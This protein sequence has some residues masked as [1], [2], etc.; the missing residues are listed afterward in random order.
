MLKPYEAVP[1]HGHVGDAGAKLSRSKDG[2]VPDRSSFS[3]GIRPGHAVF[4][5]TGLGTGSLSGPRG[6]ETA[7]AE[8]AVSQSAAGGAIKAIGCRPQGRELGTQSRAEPCR[9]GQS[10]GAESAAGGAIEAQEEERKQESGRTFQTA[11]A[12]R[13][14]ASRRRQ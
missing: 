7:T 10:E 8:L 1:I 14:T 5:R 2:N 13:A 12:G 4:K 9:S 11:I 6:K 3:H